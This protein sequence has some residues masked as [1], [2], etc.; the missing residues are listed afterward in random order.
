MGPKERPA[1]GERRRSAEGRLTVPA[2]VG[3]I[4]RCRVY[5]VGL[6]KPRFSGRESTGLID[7]LGGVVILLRHDGAGAR[8]FAP[9]D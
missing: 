4:T 6:L 7:A 3:S 2:A 9:A 5:V 8:G 1:R